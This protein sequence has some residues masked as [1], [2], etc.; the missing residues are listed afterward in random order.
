M[1]TGAVGDGHHSIDRMKNETKSKRKR[2]GVRTA[3]RLVPP[4][5]PDHTPAGVLS[6]NLSKLN[7]ST[8]LDRPAFSLRVRVRA[9]DWPANSDESPS[10]GQYDRL[11]LSNYR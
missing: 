10:R 9:Q 2:Q 1:K 6:V 7:S 5:F 3:R 8:S 11:L 4:F